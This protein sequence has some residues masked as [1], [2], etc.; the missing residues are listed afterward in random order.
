MVK[1]KSAREKT[2][3]VQRNKAKKRADFSSEAIKA[4]R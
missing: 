2:F 4:R 3:Y 1:R